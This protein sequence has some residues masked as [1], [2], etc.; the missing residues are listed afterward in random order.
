MPRQP[1][2]HAHRTG[3]GAAARLV[4]GQCAA[5]GVKALALWSVTERLPLLNED[6]TVS[7]EKVQEAIR[8]AEESVW[9]CRWVCTS[10]VRAISPAGPGTPD[11]RQQWDAVFDGRRA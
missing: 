5:A 2:H 7:A 4:E 3:R 6:G 9:A 8:T 1:K 11:A 10:S